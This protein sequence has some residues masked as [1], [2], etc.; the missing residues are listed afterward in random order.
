M[1]ITVEAKQIAVAIAK[2][3]ARIAVPTHR[4]R[5]DV[6]DVQIDPIQIEVGAREFPGVRFAFD[7]PEGFGVTLHVRLDQFAAD[8]AGYLADLF[9]RI[10]AMRI[11]AKQ[12]RAG[13]ISNALAVVNNG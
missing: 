8:P 10:S 1:K 3:L 6:G 12:Q 7:V 9:Q 5:P 11:Q 4:N 13:T 2:Q